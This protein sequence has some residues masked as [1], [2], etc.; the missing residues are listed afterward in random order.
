MSKLSIS[1]IGMFTLL[2]MARICELWLEGYRQQVAATS[3]SGSTLLV[4]R[5]VFNI[6]A[7]IFLL[8][9][10]WYVNLVS[11]RNRIILWGYAS[12]GAFLT[13][14]L[15]L[16]ILLPLRSIPLFYFPPWA[17]SGFVSAGILAIGIIGL[18]PWFWKRS[19]TGENKG[20]DG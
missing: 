16:V 7:M 2:A 6:A 1:F 8:I 5:V 12:V 13:F 4:L 20:R 17:I 18:I 11:D 14:Y 9:L 15:Y 19:A 3:E 10:F